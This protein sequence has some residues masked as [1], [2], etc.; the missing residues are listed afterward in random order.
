MT[1]ADILIGSGISTNH[2]SGSQAGYKVRTASA[3]YA[4]YISGAD[5]GLYWVKS[6]DNEITWSDPV[7]VSLTGAN[8]GFA[9]WYDKWTPGNTGTIIMI[10]YFES[11][12]DDVFSK[13]LD[14]NGDTLG[15]EIT[16]FAGTSTSTVANTCIAVTR[17]IGGNYL[18]MFDI[19]GGTEVGTYRSTD[20]GATWGARSNTGGT[21]GA[22]YF[23]L[24][25]GFGADTQDAICIFWDRSAD[26]LSRKLYDDSGDSWSE[27]S[28]ATSMVDIASSTASPHFSITV[29]DTLN[30]I[31]LAA[32]NNRDTALQ[33]LRF[34]TID[35]SAITEGTNVVANGTDDQTLCA[36]ALDS[37]TDD[38]Y[39]FYGGKSDGSETVGTSINIY[40]KISTDDGAT[41]GS[42]TQLTQAAH[43]FDMLFTS[44]IFATT[45]TA[46]YQVTHATGIRTLLASATLP[47]SGGVATP[48]F[49]GGIIS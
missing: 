42:E 12:S 27:S 1:R 37:A 36:L 19:D 38:L 16:V 24:A 49:G 33:D 8:Q 10:V 21:E 13:T 17:M 34:W 32:W 29:H 25:P 41:W 47:A 23:L 18:C 20:A 43:N 26:E 14:T 4:F 6:T 9:I 46:M 31:C 7:I 15:S 40:Y 35:E 48:M 28:I 22:D 5:N 39:C 2:R 44:P 3:V 30:K 11:S 45:L